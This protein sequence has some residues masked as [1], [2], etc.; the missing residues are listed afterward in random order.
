M[1]TQICFRKSDPLENNVEF[2]IWSQSDKY[3]QTEY[4]SVAGPAVLQY[5][6]QYFNVPFPLPKQDMIAIPGYL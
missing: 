6:E 2:R 4:A 1:N 5:Y 3:D